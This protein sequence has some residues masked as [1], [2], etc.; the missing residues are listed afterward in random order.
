MTVREVNDPIAVS[1]RHIVSFTMG[2]VG[3][4]AKAGSTSRAYLLGNRDGFDMYYDGSHK[5]TVSSTGAAETF[6]E[7][8]LSATLP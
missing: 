6:L 5:I 8:Q 7:D 2:K 1:A 3:F 4:D